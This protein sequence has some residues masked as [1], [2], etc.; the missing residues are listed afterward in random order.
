MLHDC[1]QSFDPLFLPS[2]LLRRTHDTASLTVHKSEGTF[3]ARSSSRRFASFRTFEIPSRV[4]IFLAGGQE[5]G[6]ERER[7]KKRDTLASMCATCYIG[8]H[9]TTRTT[10]WFG[11]RFTL[12]GVILG[13]GSMRASDPPPVMVETRR[14]S[15]DRGPSRTRITHSG[16]HGEAHAQ[17]TRTSLTDTR[18][19][20]R[21][22]S[23]KGSS[24]RRSRRVATYGTVCHGQKVWQGVQRVRKSSYEIYDTWGRE[25][26]RYSSPRSSLD[27]L[28]DCTRI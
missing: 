1:S 26:T 13:R 3:L 24:S 18:L 2:I 25:G 17:R 7:K 28:L 19:G 9:D 16:T 20:Q 10:S 15:T 27:H 8:R 4:R 11:G 12:T 21:G 14:G 6:R 5:E 23:V 22:C